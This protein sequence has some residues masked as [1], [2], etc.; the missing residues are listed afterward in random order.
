MVNTLKA[1]KKSI[2][3]KK[4][5]KQAGFTLAELLIVVA[6]MAILAAIAVPMYLG[7]M[8]SATKRVEQSTLASATSMAATDFLVNDFKTETQYYI[9]VSKT[10]GAAGNV[11]IRISTN[12]APATDDAIWEAW[13]PKKSGTTYTIKIGPGGQIVESKFS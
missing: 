6:I 8:D 1:D 10:A 7:Q 4:L 12:T 13:A 5:K 11:N 9:Q 3:L 2:L